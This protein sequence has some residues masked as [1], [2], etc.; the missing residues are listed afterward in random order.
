MGMLYDAY[1]GPLAAA[2]DRG[3]STTSS[4]TVTEPILWSDLPPVAAPYV[5]WST[6]A[7]ADWRTCP[8]SCA[9]P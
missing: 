4:F 6:E 7:R 9:A 3:P 5:K 1:K 2:P 8:A